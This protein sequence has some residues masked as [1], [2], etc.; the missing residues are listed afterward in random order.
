MIAII[1]AAWFIFQA[2]FFNS[3][4]DAF[5]NTP[6]FD[7]SIFKHWNKKF[8]CKDVSCNYVKTILGYRPDAWHYSKTG[9]VFGIAGA[10][11]AAYFVGKY[12]SVEIVNWFG[13]VQILAVIGAIWNG[14]F[15]LFYNLIF[16]IK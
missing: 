2:A 6:N 16:K 3:C 11:I 5:E 9:M 1:L 12:Q 8:W 10:V 15:N 14:T 4:M 7:E 13:V